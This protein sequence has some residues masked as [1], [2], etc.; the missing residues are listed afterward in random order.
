MFDRLELLIGDKINI[1]KNKTV[2]L[3]GL[4]GVGG[5]AFESLVRS[6][7]GTIIV[8]DND[9]IDVTNLNR[10]ILALKSNVGSNKVDIAEKRAKDINSEC[11]TIKIKEFITKE[12]I[13]ILFKNN[14]DFL[15]DAEDTMEVKKLII[16][17]CL[18]RKI[19][20]ISAMALGNK[21]DAS[22]VEIINLNKTTYDP[23]AKNLRL[24]VKEEKIKK[25]I[26]VIASS[27]KPLK[28]KPVGSN[29]FVPAVAGLLCTSY[30]INELL[31]EDNHG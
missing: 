6:G 27:E 12:N 25:K 30:V 9:K 17:E 18:N 8:V 23:I 3:I 2:L 31:K 20:F 24:F 19:K 7:I 13:N 21:M 22:K 29:A 10:Q 5:Y 28:N 14:I 4:G 15:I 1:L 26:M 11:K 16:K